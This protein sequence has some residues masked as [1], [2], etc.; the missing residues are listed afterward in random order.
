ML[1]RI[2]RGREETAVIETVEGERGIVAET[3]EGQESQGGNLEGKKVRSTLVD[4][5]EA[6]DH[7]LLT[8]V[9]RTPDAKKQEYR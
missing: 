7:H 3:V 6:P 4:Q 5:K 2:G 9:N 8:D 1:M